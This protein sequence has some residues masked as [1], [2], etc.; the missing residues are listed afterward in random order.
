MLRTQGKM[1]T[2]RCEVAMR[3]DPVQSTLAEVNPRLLARV[4]RI[5]GVWV[6]VVSLCWGA[7]CDSPV[8][9]Y[10]A[11][12]PPST[13]FLVSNPVPLAALNASAGNAGV[14]GAEE[15]YVSLP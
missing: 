1:N 12:L 8:Q 15:V 5:A 13:P 9:P 14:A 11:P 7:A 6:A 2:L 3:P 10:R 4:A